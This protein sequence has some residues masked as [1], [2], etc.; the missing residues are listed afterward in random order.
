MMNGRRMH[1]LRIKES[2]ARITIWIPKEQYNQL[3]Q[4]KMINGILMCQ[5]ITKVLS[6]RTDWDIRQTR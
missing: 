3:V 1:V 4:R 2:I 6:W 5:S